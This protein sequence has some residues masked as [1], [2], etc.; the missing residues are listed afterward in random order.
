MPKPKSFVHSF[1]IQK[2]LITTFQKYPHLLLLVKSG[3]Q[4]KV[5]NLA[6]LQFRILVQEWQYSRWLT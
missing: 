1:Q 5:V 2:Y 3:Q 6:Y 4:F